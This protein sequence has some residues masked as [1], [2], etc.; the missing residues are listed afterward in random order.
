[1][2]GEA[3]RGALFRGGRATLNLRD[4][5]RHPFRSLPFHA[6]AFR[7]RPWNGQRLAMRPGRSFGGFYA[8]YIPTSQP[9]DIHINA[10]DGQTLRFG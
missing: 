8:T 7:W 10:E 2:T 9:D 3:A 6:N 1:M 5:E 4:D